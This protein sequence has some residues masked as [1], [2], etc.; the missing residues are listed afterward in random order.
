M[1]CKL[2]KYKKKRIIKKAVFCH[3]HFS[4]V[5]NLNAFSHLVSCQH[6]L[7]AKKKNK[8]KKRG[9]FSVPKFQIL[10]LDFSSPVS[11]V[12][13]VHINMQCLVKLSK[14]VSKK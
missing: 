6:A 8:K 13:F 4:H 10:T 14:E 9:F 1:S 11:T 5:P 7:T 12:Q 3:M 2:I